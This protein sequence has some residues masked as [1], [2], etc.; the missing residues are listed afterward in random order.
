MEDRY[1]HR[2]PQ[3]ELGN[4]WVSKYSQWFDRLWLFDDTTAGQDRKRVDWGRPLAD[5][6]CLLDPEWS[7]FLDASRRLLWSLLTERVSG[8]PFKP[9]SIEGWIYGFWRLVDWMS[10]ADYRRM[11]ELCEA[12][13][14]EYLDFLR[15]LRM[16]EPEDPRYPFT[17]ASVKKA[18]IPLSHMWSQTEALEAAG[19][20]TLPKEPFRGRTA[21]SV[22]KDIMNSDPGSYP[23]VDDITFIAT[24]N[25]LDSW[26]TYK[27]E[28]I[29]RLMEIVADMEAEFRNDIPLGAT[30]TKGNNLLRREFSAFRF[31]DDPL[32]GQPWHK[33][34]D[35][36]D[37]AKHEVR[38]LVEALNMAG[39]IAVQST[40]GMRISEVCGLTVVPGLHGTF[41]S[42]IEITTSACGTFEIFLIN[43]RMFKTRSVWSEEK[44][45]AGMRTRGSDYIPL[46]V[47]AICLIERLFRRWREEAGID[48]IFLNMSSHY[49][50]PV[51]VPRVKPQRGAPLSQNRWIQQYVGHNPA[52]PVTSHR[53]RKNFGM[54]LFRADE[55]LL[56][57]ISLQFHHVSLAMTEGYTRNDLDLLA[58]FDQEAARNATERLYLMATGQ[59][60]LVGPVVQM[61]L[62][63]CETLGFRM[64]N[65]TPADKMVEIERIVRENNI[66]FWPLR[67]RGSEYAECIMRSCNALCRATRIGPLLRPD[68]IR[69]NPELCAQCSN[70]AVN[71]SHVTFWLERLESNTLIY[72]ANKTTDIG[73]AMLAIKRRD[74]CLTV[75]SWFEDDS[76]VTKIA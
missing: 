72:E 61:I 56:P 76:G 17:I 52:T 66:R 25:A 62:K 43:G 18:L 29:I 20:E 40:V 48:S 1:F 54:F 28:D 36:S 30:T 58:I 38:K 65:Y 21:N 42:C 3:A 55:R 5:G 11:N 57:A 64:G 70:M 10:L 37:S 53:W 19:V 15:E 59:K 33:P 32:T 13:I 23:A 27:G 7:Q 6:S 45:V 51:T 31:T 34:L 63:R 44:W 24:V 60:P 69:A 8:R 4:P 26:T 2:F 16:E 67:K 49:G 50:L 9:G 35:D 73:V 75:L 68:L 41:V 47:R 14:E 71:E 39:I 74:Q 12:A 22:A 46:P